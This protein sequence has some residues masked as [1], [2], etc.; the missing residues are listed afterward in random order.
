MRHISEDAAQALISGTTFAR[1][2]TMVTSN[3][4]GTYTMYLFGNA[5]ARTTANGDVEITNAGYNTNTTND[6]L[7]AVLLQLQGN[8][9]IQL[10]T[11]DGTPYFEYGFGNMPNE[12]KR[13]EFQNVYYPEWYFESPQVDKH[14]RS[15]R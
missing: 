3:G 14:R 2:N 8:Y 7:R 5:I 11:V 10:R 1:S 15:E 9:A 6:R 4:D 13:I 12:Y